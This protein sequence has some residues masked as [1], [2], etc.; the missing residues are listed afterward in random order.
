MK[1]HL[2]GIVEMSIFLGI[3]LAWGIW[4]LVKL[5]REQARDRERER[6]QQAKARP[7]P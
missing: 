5:R 7:E 3:P 4:E 1:D 2:F 6:E